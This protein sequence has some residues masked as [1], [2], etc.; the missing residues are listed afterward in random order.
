[1]PLTA[2]RPKCMVEVAGQPIVAHQL[3]WLADQGVK[4][5]MISCGYRWQVIQQ[6]AGDGSSFGLQVGYAIE[7][8]PLGRGGGLRNALRQLRPKDESVV[9]NGDLLT[10]VSLRT[11]RRAHRRNGAVATLLLVPAVSGHDIADVDEAGRI[12]GF[13][14]KP[15]LP[16]FWSGGVYIVSPEIERL[17]PRRG[18]HEA[19]TWPKLAVH[20]KL[21]G[22]RYTGFWQPV[23]SAK[24]LAEADRRLRR[25]L[26]G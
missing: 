4:H 9:C 8:T 25:K 7:E 26:A 23:D 12:T 21:H 19:T 5:V 13:R 11:M 10:S 6:A 18:D 2:D 24:D 3:K 16:Y 14:E 1:M 17:L 20:G 22:Y 15:A